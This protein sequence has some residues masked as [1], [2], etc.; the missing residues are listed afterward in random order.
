[1]RR[2]SLIA[3][4]LVLLAV[5]LSFAGRAVSQANADRCTIPPQDDNI[6]VKACAKGGRTEAKR[7]MKEM[8]KDAKR[9]G[10]KFTCEQCHK[11]LESWELTPNAR[12][13]MKKLLAVLG[14]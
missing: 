2:S 6:V 14:K 4:V 11:D 13:D 8:V 3:S 9:K 5:S 12:A 10:A 1:M 7:L